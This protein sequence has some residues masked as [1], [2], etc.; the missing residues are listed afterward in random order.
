MLVATE[1]YDAP[2]T[3]PEVLTIFLVENLAGILAFLV[4]A[5]GGRAGEDKVDSSS[6]KIANV[7]ASRDGDSDG[8][9]EKGVLDTS[10]ITC[11]GDSDSETLDTK[12]TVWGVL[13][14][15][16]KMG[17]DA[18]LKGSPVEG[19]VA[20]EARVVN[21]CPSLEGGITLGVPEYQNVLVTFAPVFWGV[22][23]FVLADG[24]FLK[25]VK[26]DTSGIFSGERNEDH[27]RCRV[28]NGMDTAEGVAV[29]F[30]R[31]NVSF[32]CTTGKE[33]VAVTFLASV[34]ICVLFRLEPSEGMPV[35]KT[36]KYP[37]S[38]PDTV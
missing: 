12:D 5:R 38:I 20:A 18:F 36:D 17:T 10:L 1:G 6:E 3:R 19:T 27:F 28:K 32:G 9:N 11:R 23:G 35:G 34:N 37:G 15:P 30:T 26:V 13:L 21:I 16:I 22:A 31:N 25:V 4:C 8:D 24:N 33:G 29:G 14:S 7:L 2:V